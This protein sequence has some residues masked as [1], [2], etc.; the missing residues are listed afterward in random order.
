MN[1]KVY[2][3]TW[4]KFRKGRIHQIYSILRARRVYIR[5]C[6]GPRR[7]II[8]KRRSEPCHNVILGSSLVFGVFVDQTVTISCPGGQITTMCSPEVVRDIWNY[9]PKNLIVMGGTNNLFDRNG[10]KFMHPIQVRDDMR[11]LLVF[12]LEC[13]YNVALMGLISREGEYE[14]ISHLNRLYR[15]LA[16]DLNIKFF[17]TK[18]FRHRVHISSDG[19][20]PSP[21]GVREL[22]KDFYDSLKKF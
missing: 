11:E 9:N 17:R 12:Y 16:K 10:R 14:T 2:P 1:P 6:Y 20:H 19:L 4:R 7:K 21:N 22:A 15:Q 18:K 8:K 13:G 5:E 3:E